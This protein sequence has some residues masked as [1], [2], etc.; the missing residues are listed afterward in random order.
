VAVLIRDPKKA[1]KP[2]ALLSTKLVHT[3]EQRLNWVVR[4]WTM[5]VTFEEVQTHRGMETQRQWTARAIVR[6]TPALLSLYSLITLT[7]QRLLE[8]GATC[9]RSTAWYRK[10]RPTFADALAWVRCHVWDHTHFSMSQQETDMI[11]VP[12]AL[13]ERFID[14]VCYAA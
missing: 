3:P 13:C 4:R 6:T 14:A 11:K 7:A 10:T 5:E 2:P 8:Q 12:R 1:F 9:L